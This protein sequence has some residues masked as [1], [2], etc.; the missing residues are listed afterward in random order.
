M[1]LFLTFLIVCFSTLYGVSQEASVQIKV[2]EKSNSLL[3][4]STKSG[5]AILKQQLQETMK[6]YMCQR[7]GTENHVNWNQPFSSTAF[8]PHCGVCGKKI[9]AQI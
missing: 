7:C 1:R 9:L 2:T 6:I 3:P 4:T 5:K 8:L